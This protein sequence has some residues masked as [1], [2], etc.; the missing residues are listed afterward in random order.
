MKSKLLIGLLMVAAAFTAKAQTSG[1][2]VAQA[3]GFTDV[4]TGVRNVSAVDSN[5]VWISSYDGSGGAGNRQDFSRTIDGGTTW[6]AGVTGAP[7]TYDWS[8][9]TA[10]DADNAWALYYDAVAGAGGGVWHTSDGGTTWAQQGVGT[11]F[12][13]SSFPDVIHF[14]D[15]NTGVTMGDPNGGSFE[16]YT[17][18]DGGATWV[19]VPT[20]NIPPPLNATEYGIV[21]HYS[22]VGNEIWFD[23]N[24]GR[25]YHS[26]D[27]GLNWTVAATGITVPANGAMDISFY[28]ATNGVARVYNNTTGVN[29]MK[30]TADAGLTWT[31]ATPVGNFFGSDFKS[32]PGTSRLVS[33]GAAPGFIGSSYSDDGGLTWVTIETSAQRTALGVVDSMHLWTGGFTLDPTSG[34]IYSFQTLAPIPCGDPTVNAGVGIMGDSVVCFGDNATFSVTGAVA[35]TDGSDNGFA[36]LVSTADLMGTTDPLNNPSVLGGT[37]VIVVNYDP[38]NTSLLND[39]NVFPAGIYYFTPIVFG[40]AINTS[41]QTNIT[42]YTLDPACTTTGASVMV[43]LLVSGSPLCN[44]TAVNE[45]ADSKLAMKSFFNADKNIELTIN[46]T[47]NSQTTVNVTDITGRVVYTSAINLVAGN[48]HQV[49]NVSDL[50][51]GI[52][53]LKVSDNNSQATQRLIKL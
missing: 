26:I 33:T 8:M 47:K 19:A 14:W 53:I 17:T 46:A 48:N 49:L 12:N 4:S 11:I 23:T 22:V 37:G 35:P 34:G 52:Y 43:N 44:P 36:I 25:V 42:G 31:A 32:V 20:A 51:A 38:F 13:A 45:I 6:A 24:K 16:I 7:T 15:A 2:W 29:T 21:G 28:S 27:Q 10:V 50:K 5:V 40:N 30:V 39:G 18:T 1:I 9:I 3:T 41:G